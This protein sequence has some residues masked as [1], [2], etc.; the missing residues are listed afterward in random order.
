MM[1]DAL[2]QV[3]G[4]EWCTCG[5]MLWIGLRSVDMN[6]VLG[7]GTATRTRIVCGVLSMM[8]LFCIDGRSSNMTD[9]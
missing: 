2:A 4:L 9:I 3:G 6:G 1:S 7:S 8:N 5:G